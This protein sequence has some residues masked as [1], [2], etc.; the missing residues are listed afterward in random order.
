MLID[1]ARAAGFSL[2]SRNYGSTGYFDGS[3]FAL[4]DYG[5]DG[6]ADPSVTRMF[7][8]DQIS[9][10]DFRGRNWNR[11][12]D[13]EA[14]R[15][16]KESDRELIPDR[17]MSLMD[18]IYRLQADDFVSLPLYLL[19]AATAWRTDRIAGPVGVWNSSP[20]GTF[21]NTNEWYLAR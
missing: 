13:P 12:C 17:R 3:Q 14:D 16:M 21:F 2:V 5:T 15:L 20:Y 18:E 10:K 7:A 4:A 11:W 9:N 1:R 8:C 6:A 19:P